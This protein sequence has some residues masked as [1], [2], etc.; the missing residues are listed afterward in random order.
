MGRRQ[1]RKP[2]DTVNKVLGEMTETAG[3]VFGDKTLEA[4]G[5]AV[6]RKAE[7]RTYSVLPRPVGGWEIETDG[8]I[9]ASDAYEKKDAAVKSAKALARGNRPSQLLIYKK[10]GT[11]QAER[12][13]G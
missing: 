3:S 8:T 5:R 12:T 7:R 2:E 10:D 1:S 4:E 6:Q 13:Y 9:R 11:I